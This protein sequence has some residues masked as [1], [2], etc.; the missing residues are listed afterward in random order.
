M[1]IARSSR[2]PTRSPRRRLTSPRINRTLPAPEFTQLSVQEKRAHARAANLDREFIEAG[3][4]AA[5]VW[6]E[7]EIMVKRSGE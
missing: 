6:R 2:P 4:H 7:T 3:L 1:S 5:S